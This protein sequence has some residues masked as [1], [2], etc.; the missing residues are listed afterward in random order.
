MNPG[1]APAAPPTPPPPPDDSAKKI[2]CPGCGAT[3]IVFNAAT[4]KFRCEFCGKESEPNV[5]GVLTLVTTLDDAKKLEGHHLS[6]G[7]GELRQPEE[8]VVSFRCPSCKAEMSVETNS[9][10]GSISCHWCRHVISVANKINNG[11]RPDCVIPFTVPKPDA[12]KFIRA[13]LDKHKFY[14]DP[15]FTNTFKTDMIR[16]VYLPY[17]M[18]DFHLESL[19]SG[20]AAIF[21]RS[22]TVSQ[23][24]NSSKTVYDYDMYSFVRKFHLYI[25]DL[26]VEANWKYA[27]IRGKSM[28]EDSRNIVNSVLPFDTSK[29]VDYDPKVLKGDYR[30]EFRDMSFDDMKNNVK[31][32]FED[33]SVFNA[34]KT[35]TQYTS[36]HKFLNNKIDFIGD[37]VDSVLCP[38]W[39][40]SYQ[41]QK[42]KLS[43]IC[44][45]GQTGETAA[46]IPVHKGKLIFFSAIVEVVAFF[47]TILLMIAMCAS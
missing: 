47:V 39:L 33:I 44:V 34:L 12:E 30:A 40:Y 18:C 2:K 38:L 25:N 32:Q 14:A 5:Q 15:V 42:G 28:A 3:E 9:D 31:D 43:Y 1:G 22:R 35:M 6:P 37:R 24:K 36:G 11:A 4:G 41:D 16:P 7:M 20:E 13:Y 46:C 17:A 19:H 10:T 29:I 45:N 27:K 23:G 26:L 8:E 21:I